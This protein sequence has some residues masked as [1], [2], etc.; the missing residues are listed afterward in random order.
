MIQK[1]RIQSYPNF[2]TN[3][4]NNL[5]QN[6]FLNMSKFGDLRK[7]IPQRIMSQEDTSKSDSKIKS[8]VAQILLKKG[9]TIKKCDEKERTGIKSN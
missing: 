7:P 6:G 2:E 1:K 5:S 9:P 4:Q 3:N 8:A